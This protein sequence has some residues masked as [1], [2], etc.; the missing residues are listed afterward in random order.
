MDD[1]LVAVSALAVLVAPL[2][3]VVKI[4]AEGEGDAAPTFVDEVVV[5]AALHT[6][7]L[8]LEATAGY[9]VTG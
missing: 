5:R 9:T 6:V 7:A 4:L 3:F 2:A 1:V 8:M